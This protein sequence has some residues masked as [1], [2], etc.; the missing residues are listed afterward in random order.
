M[1]SIPSRNMNEQCAYLPHDAVLRGVQRQLLGAGAVQRSH[2]H[3]RPPQRLVVLTLE[4][5]VHLALLVPHHPQEPFLQAASRPKN[6]IQNRPLDNSEAGAS[7]DLLASL[8]RCSLNGIG[9]HSL[10]W[11]E[12][13]SGDRGALQTRLQ[14]QQGDRMR[15]SA[16]KPTNPALVG[17]PGAP[18]LRC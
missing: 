8:G 9:I 17:C 5:Q 3:R 16:P 11:E 2:L 12:L 4:H 18:F 1:R 7:S 6:R 15:E 14:F 13:L 10:S